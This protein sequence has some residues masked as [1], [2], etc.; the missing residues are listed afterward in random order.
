[1]SERK[2]GF[3]WKWPVIV[4]TGLIVIGI[5]IWFFIRG[6]NDVP[7]FQTAVVERGNITNV[8][9]A[10]GTLNPVVNVQI[11]CQV[12]GRIKSLY[13]DFNS[14]VKS[15]QLIAEI[16]PR[17]YEAQVAQAQ[18]DLANARANME[19]QQANAER[20]AQ[21][22]TNKLMAQADYDTAIASLH[23][24][25]AM[26]QIKE[27][28]LSNAVNNL[29]YC[30]IYSPVNGVVISRAVDVGQ[31]VAASLS[32]P[33]LF[34]IANDLTKMQIDTSVAEADVGGVTEGQ[35]V[36]FGVD[37]YPYRTFHGTVT[38]VRNSPTTVNNV[39]TYDCVIDVT[40]ADY[41]LKPGMTA[42]V[43]IITAK[44]KDI[45][46][47]PN[48]ALRI[49]VPDNVEIE[50]NSSAAGETLASESNNAAARPRQGQRFGGSGGGHSHG[51][52]ERQMIHTV[53]LF[54]GDTG[55]PKLIATHIKTGIS[56]GL[57]TE[58][59]SGLKEGDVVVTGLLTTSS[60]AT[61][62]ADNP[63]GGNHFRRR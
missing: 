43:S 38:Q 13:V 8:V 5:G 61:P 60:Q 59:L 55:H 9:T 58:V 42:N 30:K 49:H 4:L 52:S 56:D 35:Q 45:L 31:T 36:D 21:L 15:N 46:V 16:D 22:L 6:G 27:A 62:S 7:Q 53:Y 34:Q 26:V 19:L 20:D 54:A 39:V 48:A 28:A 29:G 18:A 23:E 2:S 11:G 3:S 57:S 12:S 10:T 17:T 24:A 14:E 37:A 32:A 25:A 50:T 63:F 33:V 40:N 1:M 44:N 41:K 51:N 47:I